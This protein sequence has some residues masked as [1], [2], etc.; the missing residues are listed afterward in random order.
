MGMKVPEVLLSGNHKEIWR[1]RRREA[2]KRTLQRRPDILKSVEL[3][4]EDKEILEDINRGLCPEK[5]K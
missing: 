2:I 5:N 4:G 3:S 1:W